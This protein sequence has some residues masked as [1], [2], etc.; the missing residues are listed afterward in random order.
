MSPL[1]RSGG[2]QSS[3][4]GATETTDL[5]F[6]ELHGF[7]VDLGNR[8]CSEEPPITEE[9]KDGQEEQSREGEE[10][11]PDNR[12][13]GDDRYYRHS[14]ENRSMMERGSW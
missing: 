13:V 5:G 11:T 10:M 6:E 2:F 14:C 12:E 9:K 1:Q 4:L 7:P 3:S 8:G